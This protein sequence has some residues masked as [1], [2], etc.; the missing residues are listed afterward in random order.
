MSDKLRDETLDDCALWRVDLV[1]G[2]PDE[3]G[4]IS[5]TQYV[6]KKWERVED[7]IDSCR[8]RYRG[9]KCFVQVTR[10]TAVDSE[11]FSVDDK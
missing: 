2:V 9:Q 5:D 1:N 10:L 7:L 3:G 6:T 8:I 4:I 11:S